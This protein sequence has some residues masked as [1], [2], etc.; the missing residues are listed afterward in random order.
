MR[1]VTHVNHRLTP[2]P[3]DIGRR[4]TVQRGDAEAISL[5]KVQITE[6][7]LT[8]AC[9]V[10]QQCLEHGLQ[11]AGRAADNAEHFEGGRLLLQRFVQLMSTAVE[12]FLQISSG[13]K[14]TVCGSWR[15]AALTR[16]GLSAPSFRPYAT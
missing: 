3:L 11:V 13:G 9:R 16:Y 10:R 8:E 15:I 12:L 2:P 1:K 4:R 6:L 7:G 5:A 14:A